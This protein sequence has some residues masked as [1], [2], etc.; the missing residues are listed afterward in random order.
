MK[1][2]VLSCALLFASTQAMA[3]KPWNLFWLSHGM[4]QG[5]T[6]AEFNE[7]AVEYKFTVKPLMAG[8]DTKIVKA[9]DTEYWLLFCDGKLTYASWIFDTNDEFIKS[10]DERVNS[11]DFKMTSY[12][13]SS[14]YNDATAQ[15]SNQFTMHFENPERAYSVTY[16][17]FSANA[18]VTVEDT[19]Y[20]D[21]FDCVREDS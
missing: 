11:N 21:T 9:G 20:D 10:L 14:Q 12:K 1:K 7:K 17:L 13:V 4:H 16:D 15:E 8:S 5:M 18:Q 19:A 3:Q 2:L 6:E